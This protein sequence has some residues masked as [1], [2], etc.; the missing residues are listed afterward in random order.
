MHSR[1]FLSLFSFLSFFYCFGFAQAQSSP[2][3]REAGFLLIWQPLHRAIDN[4]RE[5]QFLD[6]P[7]G[8]SHAR[9][10]RF[11]KSRGVLDDED[12]KFYPNDGLYI[13]DALTWLFRSR[14]VDDVDKITKER[15]YVYLTKYPLP[16]GD[17]LIAWEPDYGSGELLNRAGTTLVTEEQLQSLMRDL[18][19]ALRDEVHEASMY[20]EEFQGKGTAFGE[21]FD[22]NLLTA[23][24][25]T[26]P[27][28]TL[29]K[30][31]NVDNGKSVTVRINDRGP[32]VKGRDLDLSVAA[33]TS[34]ADRRLGKIHATFERIGDATI[35]G[36][37]VQPGTR[38][39]RITRSTILNPGIPHIL[40]LGD[41]MTISS[42]KA[43]VI[44]SVRYPDGNDTRLENWILSRETYSFKPS[45][46]GDYKFNLS[47]VNG[48]KRQMEMRVVDCSK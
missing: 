29:M 25:R 45:V 44:R 35:V 3:T 21:T 30:V 19:S 10:I 1:F 33:F 5:K 40:H 38:Q 13:L 8:D 26:L 11:A 15:L 41:T 7:D 47:S 18:D 32:Y 17:H 31:T 12:S 16:S 43:F 2:I 20:G 14:N 9:E 36:P 48:H 28:N 23:A 46:E 39:Q 27:Y 24:H 34:I 6:I 37:C 4:V 42:S 22:M